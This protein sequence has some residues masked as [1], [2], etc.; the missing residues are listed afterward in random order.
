[1]PT[2]FSVPAN[3]GK[4]ELPV[5]S[6][7][8]EFRSLRKQG[9]PADMYLKPSVIDAGNFKEFD[10]LVEVRVCPKWGDVATKWRC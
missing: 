9:A 4:T 10:V 1:M 8:I 2:Q 7:I 6:S 3:L 5:G